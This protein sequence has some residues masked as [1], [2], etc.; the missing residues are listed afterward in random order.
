ML[1]HVGSMWVQK[2][3]PIHR[4]VS[5]IMY[6]QPNLTHKLQLAVIEALIREQLL[7]E[8][9]DLTGAIL[10]CLWQVDVTQIQHQF[11]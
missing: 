7:Q 11:A 8:S 1:P 6:K 4:A 5:W 9:H 2:M 10:I 3:D